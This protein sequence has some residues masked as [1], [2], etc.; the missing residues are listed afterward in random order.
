MDLR[1]L[2]IIPFSQISQSMGVTILK[3]GI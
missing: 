2:L 3:L 1:V